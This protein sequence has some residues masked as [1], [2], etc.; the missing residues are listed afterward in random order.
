MSE[1][2]RVWLDA[3]A[4]VQERINE[5]STNVVTQRGPND[6]AW[7]AMIERVEAVGDWQEN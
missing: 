4:M 6:A 5:H 3:F 2:K 7:N 1:E